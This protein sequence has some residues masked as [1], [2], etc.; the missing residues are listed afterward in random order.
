[1]GGE[2][3]TD[4]EHVKAVLGNIS[5]KRPYHKSSVKAEIEKGIR[6]RRT[7]ASTL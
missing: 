1:M 6:T 5:V 4:M 3:V 7:G 2:A